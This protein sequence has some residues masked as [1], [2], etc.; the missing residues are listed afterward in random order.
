MTQLP[1]VKRALLRSRTAKKVLNSH[2]SHQ[3]RHIFSN[4]TDRIFRGQQLALSGKT[5]FDVV[6][7]HEIISLR[8]YT[9]VTESTTPK[10]RIPLV[11]V[12]PLAANMLIYDLFPHRS[13]VR[14]FL[15][16]GFDVYLIDWGTPSLR[17]AKYNLGTYVKT[18]MPDFIEK[19]RE[20]SGQQ[21]LS[22][23][24]WSLGGALSLCYTS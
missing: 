20:H 5:P 21:Q 7:Q 10:Y 16:Q 17:Q 24:G 18:F 9:T 2:T 22:L 11:I 23:Y 3:A 14:Y 12:P 1:K 13:L 8:H 4:A 6:Y 15:N 19:I